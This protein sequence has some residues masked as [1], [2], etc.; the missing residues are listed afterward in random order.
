MTLDASCLAASVGVTGT[1]RPVKIIFV[2]GRLPALRAGET[3]LRVISGGSTE[4]LSFSCLEKTAQV[5]I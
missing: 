5:K 2:V 3:L 1:M 4:D